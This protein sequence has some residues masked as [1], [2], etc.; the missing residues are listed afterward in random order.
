MK[1]KAFNKRLELNKTTV[2]NLEDRQM[3]KVKGGTRTI[4]WVCNTS[5][6]EPCNCNTSDAD[7]C[8]CNT[9]VNEPCFC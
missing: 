1:T 4:P 5:W 9:S 6:A 3:D 2:A 7:P 8:H